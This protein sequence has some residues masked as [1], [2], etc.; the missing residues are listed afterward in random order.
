MLKLSKT[1]QNH[2]SLSDE[3]EGGD[4]AY[5]GSHAHGIL[6]MLLLLGDI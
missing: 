6:V 3:L 4:I 2:P 1:P 5:M